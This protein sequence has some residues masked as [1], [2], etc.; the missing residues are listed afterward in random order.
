MKKPES[1][2]VGGFVDELVPFLPHKNDGIL[3]DML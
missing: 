2:S 3:P 1:S